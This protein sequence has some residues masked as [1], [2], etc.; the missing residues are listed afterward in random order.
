MEIK[1]AH[2]EQQLLDSRRA[3]RFEDTGAEINLGACAAFQEK[4]ICK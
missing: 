1:S 2:S 4:L 3:D